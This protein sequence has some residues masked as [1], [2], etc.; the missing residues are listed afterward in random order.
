MCYTYIVGGWTG[1]LVNPTRVCLT[2]RWKLFWVSCVTTFGMKKLFVSSSRTSI[3]IYIFISKKCAVY[4]HLVSSTLRKHE[5]GD[6]HKL[7]GHMQSINSKFI[8]HVFKCD[9][10]VYLIQVHQTKLQVIRFRQRDA[11][12][13]HK[14]YSLKTTFSN[15]RSSMSG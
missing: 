10:N 6:L 14:F 15:F 1:N 4:I 8:Y 3:C 7:N 12:N 2:M 9:V 5:S 11:L 13:Q